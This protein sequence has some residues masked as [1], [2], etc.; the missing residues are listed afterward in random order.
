MNTF[1]S[2]TRRRLVESFPCYFPFGGKHT[3]SALKGYKGN[4]RKET[5]VNIFIGFSMFLINF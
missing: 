4:Q 3:Q 2:P 1:I 5:K